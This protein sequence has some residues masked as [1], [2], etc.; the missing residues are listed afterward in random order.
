MLKQIKLHLGSIFNNKGMSIV[1]VLVAAGLTSIVALGIATMVQNMMIEQKKITLFATLKELKLRIESTVR[2]QNSWTRTIRS[3][4]DNPSA[5]FDSF[6]ASTAVTVAGATYVAPQKI[7]LLDGAGNVAFNL[8][9]WAD[10]GT[11]GFTETGATCNTFTMAGSDACPIS[12][13]LVFAT[14]CGGAATCFNPQLKVVARLVFRPAPGGT[15]NRFTNII[16]VGNMTTIADG[17]GNDGK[18]DVSIRRTATQVNRSF[19]IAARKVSGGAA[20][21][22]PGFASNC[23]A[24]GA[25]A[26]TAAV[27]PHPATAGPG[28][29]T[30]GA[31]GWYFPDGANALVTTN[32]AGT[33]TI[34][35]VGTYQCNISMSAFGS[36]GISA[37]LFRNGAQLATGNS[38]AGK[39]SGST[40]SFDTRFVHPTVGQAFDIRQQCPSGPPTVISD[41]NADTAINLCTL[42][43]ATESYT[44]NGTD[45]VVV[46]CTKI[47]DQAN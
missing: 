5:T 9:D 45:V 16:G 6:R 36:G 12:Y 22:Y 23:A 25:G 13:R 31:T 4:T 14:D 39:W 29:A 41:P 20:V 30:A 7:V 3:A 10:T 37:F 19:K 21:A 34:N 43:M 18:Y 15:L 38:V 27:A 28:T 11:A 40:V 32:P 35:E 47:E 17:A 33:F 24:N 44:L 8:L 46:T 42:G 2:D 26:C 1:E